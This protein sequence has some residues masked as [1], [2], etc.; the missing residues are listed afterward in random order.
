M[1]YFSAENE[2]LIYMFVYPWLYCKCLQSF[3]LSCLWVRWYGTYYFWSMHVS[4]SLSLLNLLMYS[5]YIPHISNLLYVCPFRVP[6]HP[7]CWFL[8]S[9]CTAKWPSAYDRLLKTVCHKFCFLY[10]FNLQFVSTCILLTYSIFSRKRL[11]WV[12]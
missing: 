12:I 8:T 1:H 3:S 5:Q 7:T 2:L 11:V 10:Y 4:V 9:V 6:V